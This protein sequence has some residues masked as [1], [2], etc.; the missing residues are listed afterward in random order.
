MERKR[1]LHTLLLRDQPLMTKLTVYSALL[2][3]IP[4]MLVGWMAY[5]ESTRA[6]ENEA[7]QYS[8]QIIEQVKIYVEDYLRDFELSTLRMVN[9]PDT[10]AF[11]KMTSLEEVSDAKLAPAVRNVLK[12]SAYSRS[13][14]TN[15]TLILDGVQT[16]SST[17]GRSSVA[18]IEEEYWYAATPLT[19]PPKV[20]SRV[21]DWN[22]RREPVLSI[23]KRIGN[24]MTLEPYGM[25]VID[26]NYKRL[27][28]VAREVKLGESGRGYLFILDD[29]G[30]FVYH[31]DPSLIGT[32]AA[33]DVTRPMGREPSGSFVLGR[34]PHQLLLTYSRSESLGWQV[35]TSIPYNEIM[36]SRNYIGQTIVMITAVSAVIALLLS[37]GL[38]ASIVKPIKRIY[39]YMKRVE[40]GDLKK[41][42]PIDRS[43]ELGKLSIG[44]NTMVDRLSELLEEVY[45]SKL[46][47]TEMH[48]QQKE[49]E[50]KM[51]QAQINPHF[52]YNS[53]DTI[54][55]MALAAEIDEIEAMAALLARLLRYNVKESSAVVTVRDEVGMIE[56]YLRIQQFRFGEKL[57]YS[58]EI[59]E[60]AMQQKMLKFTLQPI[61]ENAIVHALE[62]RLEVTR[63]VLSA[64]RLDERSFA[65][66]VCDNGPGIPE[67]TIAEMVRRLNEGAA[68]GQHIGLTNVHRRIRHV[69]GE[70]GFGLSLRSKEREGTEVIIRLPYEGEGFLEG[71]NHG[72]QVS[73]AAG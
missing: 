25:L 3:V 46:R 41:K 68:E 12:N 50:L 34:S 47:E 73:G 22:G 67:K 33:E 31:P 59:P 42:L 23:V 24:P 11:L 60:W 7:K 37:I 28:E 71:D 36:S 5:R 30:R 8:W 2:V 18:G 72:E 44:F 58:I 1:V 38:A 45:F 54:R 39:Q 16:I 55:G 64:Q 69:F 40:I 65:V 70:G 21:I 43:D 51:L 53:L 26:V 10:A 66:R 19:G 9:H 56:V 62:K 6:L 48:L 13:D 29:Q 17:D 63:I 20:Y 32:Q 14:V 35:V 57:E 61:V 49:M 15:I 27:H 52:L 4:M